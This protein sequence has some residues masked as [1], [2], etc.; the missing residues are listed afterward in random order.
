MN[1]QEAP[2]FTAMISE[3]ITPSRIVEVNKRPVKCY[4]D[5]GKNIDN[6]TVKSFG[7]EWKAFHKFDEDELQRIGDEYFDIVTPAMY[8]KDKIAADFGCGTGRWTKYFAPRVGAIAA[9]DP[10]DA[11]FTAAGVLNTVDNAQLYKASIDNLPFPNNYFD[12]GFSLGVLHHIPDT[13]RAMKACIDK[14]RPGGYF[15][16]YLYYNFDNRGPLFK[17]IYKLSNLIRLVVSKLPGGIKRFFCNILAI[18]LYMPFVGLC[19]LLRMFGV[20]EKIRQKIP[21]Q[22]YEKASFYIIRNDA[23]DRFGTPLE[24]RFTKKEITGMMTEAGLSEINFSSNAPYWHAT[25]KKL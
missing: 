19:R 14:I 13:A 3:Q 9:I 6:V 5:L 20:P 4:D 25:G 16:V 21:L 23:L 12:F 2:K 7:E 10:S 24:Q 17:F 1:L 11:I 22:I 15:L 8:G 18:V